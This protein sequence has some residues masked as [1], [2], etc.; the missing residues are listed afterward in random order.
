MIV[1]YIAHQYGG[2]R[3]DLTSAKRYV[4]LIASLG[5]IAPIAPWI[6][7]CEMWDE[8]RREEGLAIDIAV[9]RRCDVV[10]LCGPSISSG[11]LRESFGRPVVDLTPLH[12][13]D[14]ESPRMRD[15]LRM[16]IE[17]CT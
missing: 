16:Y 8:S 17:E 10:L 2:D 5:G 6:T 14:F 15:T 3:S 7:L 11:M 13:E 1:A 9:A 4:S 12:G